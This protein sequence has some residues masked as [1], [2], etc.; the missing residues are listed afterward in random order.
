MKGGLIKDRKGWEERERRMKAEWIRQKG[1]KKYR[2][3]MKEVQKMDRK[4]EK[5]E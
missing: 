2:R 5:E 4:K 3:R 1:W